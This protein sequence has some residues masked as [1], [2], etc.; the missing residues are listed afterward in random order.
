MGITGQKACEIASAGIGVGYGAVASGVSGGSLTA[1]AMLAGGVFGYIIGRAICKI[2][3]LERG[4]DRLLNAGDWSSLEL[5]AN[6]PDVHTDF[7]KLAKKDIGLQ[8]KI[9]EDIWLLFKGAVS[10]KNK[11]VFENPEVRSAE[12]HPPTGGAKH[13]LAMLGVEGST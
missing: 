11:A 10:N 7:I 1:P 8:E 5:A 6:D 9:A 3:A 12:Y 13:G 4:F 2:T